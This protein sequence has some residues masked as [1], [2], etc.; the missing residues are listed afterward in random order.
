MPPPP[1]QSEKCVKKI[2]ERRRECAKS[3]AKQ[4]LL[5]GFGHN[6]TRPE[7]KSGKKIMSKK[8]VLFRIFFPA[9]VR[10]CFFL[11]R[12][13]FSSLSLSLVLVVVV[14]VRRGR[15]RGVT[16]L[17][18]SSYKIFSGAAGAKRRRLARARGRERKAISTT[19]GG[20][21]R[22]MPGLF[23]RSGRGGGGGGGQDTFSRIFHSR[24][25]GKRGA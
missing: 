17:P 18:F 12:K 11:D 2:D 7:K 5:A 15:E 6:F 21:W 19:G 9:G 10:K 1:P 22:K 24:A 23:S 20:R 14:V 3:E 4:D 16:F 25:K 8:K 13:D